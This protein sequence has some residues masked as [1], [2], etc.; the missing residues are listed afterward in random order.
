MER[1]VYKTGVSGT[2]LSVP[3]LA[4]KE[5][6]GRV[7]R[8]GK[9]YRLTTNDPS[10]LQKEARWNKA[11]GKLYFAFDFDNEQIDIPYES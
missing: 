8:D 11:L 1:W 7:Y 2:V 9:E 5:I 3:E 10:I 4:G 6:N